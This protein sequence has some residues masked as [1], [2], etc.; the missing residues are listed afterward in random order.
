M[1]LFKAFSRS[2]TY[3]GDWHG[4][5]YLFYLDLVFD[6]LLWPVLC[7][8]LFVSVLWFIDGVRKYTDWF[9]RFSKDKEDKDGQ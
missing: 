8:A 5:E 7:I 1:A 2:A 3:N 9:S 4:F 6:Y